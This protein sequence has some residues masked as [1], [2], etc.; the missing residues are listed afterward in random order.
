MKSLF[1]IIIVI[2]ILCLFLNEAGINV[3]GIALV[4]L[5][6]WHGIWR[7][8]DHIEKIMGFED[9]PLNSAIMSISIGLI[10]AFTLNKFHTIAS[11]T[12]LEKRF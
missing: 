2:L 6:L 3:V 11:F 7:L 10:V 5:F 9:S 4:T 12:Y 1:G 8:I